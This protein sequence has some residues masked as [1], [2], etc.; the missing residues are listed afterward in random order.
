MTNL[1]NLPRLYDYGASA[2]CYKAR[3]LLAQLERPYERVPTDIFD[4]ATLGADF[5]R[6][7]PLRSTPVIEL[8][9][10]R[11]LIESNAILWWLAS[12]T[13]FLP[14]DPLDQADVC[15]W[16]IFEQTDVMP[17]IGGL[18]FR[19]LTGRL[20]HE[21][22][23]AARRRAGAYEALGVLDRHLDGRSYLVAGRYSIADI[24]VFAYT[25]VAVEAAIDLAPYRHVRA[26]LERIAEQ[27]LFVDDLE[28]YP[29]NASLQVGR[30][31]YG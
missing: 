4:G 11:T 29:P 15:R 13:P 20:T 7:N 31:I 9:D 8:P 14:T 19:L 30:S 18:R 3:L 25:H 10:G 24:A 1:E 16:L 27:P 22:D 6:L 5:I 17:M 2:N 28:P 26:W 12:G 23:E 21:S